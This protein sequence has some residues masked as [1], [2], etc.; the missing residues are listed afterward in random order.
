MTPLRWAF[1]RR[2]PDPLGEGVWARAAHTVDRAV[3][4]YEQMV[5]GCPAGPVRAELE[6]FLPRMDAVARRAHAVCVRAQAQA[7]STQLT[8][9]GG[10]HGE[11][12]RRLTRTATACAQAAEAAAMA[13]VG[14]DDG[15]AAVEER[16]AAVGRA[17]ERAEQL[18]GD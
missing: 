10:A 5:D 6:V 16:V 8:V 1:W 17:V 2:P 13:R 4:R 12:H 18:V 3:R 9:P 7:P 15:T 14:A 11:L